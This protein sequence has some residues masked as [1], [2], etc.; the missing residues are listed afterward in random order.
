MKHAPIQLAAATPEDG[1]VAIQNV[2]ATIAA[3]LDASFVEAGGALA[4][5]YDIVEKLVGALDGVTNALDREAADAAIAKMRMTAD[6]LMRLPKAQEERGCVLDMIQQAGKALGDPVAQINRLLRFLRI[7]GLNIKVAGAGAQDFSSFSDTIFAKLDIG[8]REMNDIGREVEQLVASIPGVLEVDRQLAAECARVIPHVPLK[9]AGDALALQQHQAEAA[10][11]A[12][13][14]ADLARIVRAQVATALGALQIGDITRQ[15]LEHVVDGLRGLDAF[16]IERIASDSP[17]REEIRGYVLALLAAQTDDTARDF[18]RESQLLIQ[19]IGAIAPGARALLDLRDPGAAQDGDSSLHVVE[20]SI[21]EIAG[22]TRQLQDADARANLLSNATSATAESLGQHLRNI[23][24]M[25][26]DVQQMAWNTELRGN[27]MGDAGRA[28]A[29]VATEIRGFAHRLE[30]IS[31]V[32]SGLFDRLAGAAGAIRD[33][34]GEGADV[35]QA[36]ADSLACLRDGGERLRVGLSGLD[37]DA[38]AVAAILDETTDKVDCA[39]ASTALADIVEQL[40][41]VAA[42]CAEPSEETAAMLCELLDTIARSYTMA[43]ERAVHRRFALAGDMVALEAA[44][45]DDDFDDG[46]F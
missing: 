46:L 31:A 37:R 19:S 1:L 36:L 3:G 26:K 45:D 30:T 38:A 41:L 24:R 15:R 18:A 25:N 9:L 33:P 23:H 14:I 42:P 27:R 10:D 4:R 34:E 22:V 29:I 17:G 35:G 8:E 13:R 40:A 12:G 32:I 39:D 43:S 16:L 21:T 2:L 7:C 6:R 20:R 28:L 44:F 11:R 5:A